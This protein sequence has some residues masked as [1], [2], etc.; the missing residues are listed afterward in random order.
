MKILLIIV[1]TVVALTA[2][3]DETSDVNSIAL[4]FP[5]SYTTNSGAAGTAASS[6]WALGS[7]VVNINKIVDSEIGEYKTL[8]KPYY[9]EAGELDAV[10]KKVV[11]EGKAIHLNGVSGDDSLIAFYGYVGQNLVAQFN[12]KVLEVQGVK[13]SKRRAIWNNKLTLPFNTC[14]SKAKNAKFD[15]SHCMKAL[16][17]SVP[18]NAG[19]AIT[20]ELSNSLLAGILPEEDRSKFNLDQVK[21]YRACIG[22]D[23]V[24]IDADS[25]TK[26]ALKTM[27]QGIEYVTDIA[28][29]KTINEKA[30]SKEKAKLVKSFIW[31]FFAACT[32]SIINDKKGP[33]AV[34]FFGCIDS[35]V[36]KTGAELVTDKI[37]NTPTIKSVFKG[38]EAIG[39]ANEKS[40]QFKKCAE[41]QIK[42]GLR[43]DGILNVDPCEQQITNEVTYKVVSE[44]L[45][46]NAKSTLKTDPQSAQKMGAA[47]I[48]LLNQCWNNKQIAVE[49]EGCIR[50]TILTFSGK[51]ANQ[52]LE[53][54]VTD[55]MPK[56]EE[57]LQSSV[58][59]LEKCLEAELP[60]NISEA[61]DLT[62]RIDNCTGKLTK[63]V[64]LKVANHMVRNT[65][66]GNIPDSSVNTIVENLVDKEFANCIGN[67]PND[68]QLDKCTIS[69]TTKAA[70]TISEMSFEKE[71][72]AYLKSAGGLKFLGLT[73]AQV[74]SFLKDLNLSNKEC[75]DK[76]NSG[77]I[78]DQ[79][80][81]CIK[82]SVKKIAFFFGDVQFNKSVGNMYDKRQNDKKKIQTQFREALST[83][84]SQKDGK[85]FTISDYT[86]N[87]YVCSDNISQSTTLNVGS[88]QIETSLN[89][90]L[91]DRP[92]F[93]LQEKR[94]S[95]RTQ[96]M[97]RFTTCMGQEKTTSKCI[98]SLKREA[99]GLIVINYGRAETKAQLNAD[100]P[101]EELKKVEDALNKCV[102]TK[103]EG[104]E[105]S[106]HLDRCTETFAL[107]FAR[108]LGALKLN[109]LLTQTL[110]TKE[111]Q[112][113]KKEITDSL[114][115][116]ND[117]LDGL[118]KYSMSEGLTEKL[119]I[120][121]DGLT[122]T[123]MNI[124]RNSLKSWMTAD[125]KDAATLTI[126]KG[127]ADFLPCLS[128]L[129]PTSPYSPILQQNVESSVKVLAISLSRYTRD[130]PANAQMT[131]EGIIKI[132]SID[133]NDVATT[134]KAKKDLLD[135]LYE[136]KGLDQFIQSLV[137]GTIQDA[138]V[139]VPDSE[140]PQNLR[141]IMLKKEIFEELF[142]TPEGVKIQ[143]D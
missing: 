50:K 74:D 66:K 143:E 5:V 127:F 75:I 76:K 134:A 88:D 2:Y 10:I 28:L 40:L 48:A 114:E 9:P 86:K 87:L 63:L 113:Q 98:D 8:L 124:V 67:S 27:R 16:S 60:T 99:T 93:S 138:L 25:A 13:D 90:Y 131:L 132:L 61:S 57:L 108:E 45:K 107:G 51:V 47:G 72:N 120:C 106:K 73:Q 125:E 97:S 110:G 26:C 102:D 53:L 69:L 32:G 85:Q 14:I 59:D 24:K 23:D 31:P 92:G 122:R 17:S 18:I 30:S 36:T 79:V 58:A 80:N 128:A 54:V 89:E 33:Y 137:K 55:D 22:R 46:N 115:D 71:V 68:E 82:S 103:L 78:M 105:L 6:I 29:S 37:L 39:L 38:P 19:L 130:N 34:Q 77:V 44:T 43:K 142:K 81:L 65:A 116:Y 112:T 70:K 41:E 11:D 84:L 96:V 121:T 42:K 7:N 20:Y 141:D 111:F 62:K 136:K 35:L 126:I 109:Y 64:A 91:K 118:K 117:C 135:F 21:G 94:E 140:V 52:K 4:S 95:I 56:K 100:A 123:G 133:F 101:P 119:S 83:C 129:L 3:A 104:D 139:D 49:R 12:D 1:L 15:A